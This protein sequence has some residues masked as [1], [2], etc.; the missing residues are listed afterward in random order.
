MPPESPLL[1]LE[2]NTKIFINLKKQK[3]SLT[4]I[5]NCLKS[6]ICMQFGIQDTPKSD[7][8]HPSQLLSP[9]IPFPVPKVTNFLNMSFLST[10]KPSHH[11]CF[12]SQYCPYLHCSLSPQ[13]QV[14]PNP[15]SW[16]DHITY[17]P[18]WDDLTVKGDVSWVGH[19]DTR[20]KLGLTQADRVMG[21]LYTKPNSSVHL[22]GIIS[23]SPKTPLRFKFVSLFNDHF[24][25]TPELHV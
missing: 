19:H 12:C 23:P 22:L 14:L 15:Q 7:L 6:K 10:P 25:C 1:Y 13:S 11:P 5:A 16:R 21:S 8:K 17:H 3:S 9:M 2:G 4:S 18:N 24:C 20:S